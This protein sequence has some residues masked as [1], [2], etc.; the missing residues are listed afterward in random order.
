LLDVPLGQPN[1]S[2]GTNDKK[3]NVKYRDKRSDESKERSS[4]VDIV[5]IVESLVSA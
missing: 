4:S 3:A 2:N 1:N 5:I